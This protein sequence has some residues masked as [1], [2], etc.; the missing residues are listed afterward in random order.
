MGC[1]HSTSWRSALKR[2]FDERVSS[3]ARAYFAYGP[4]IDGT[5]P[6][7]PGS[8]VARNAGEAERAVDEIAARPDGQTVRAHFRAASVE[9]K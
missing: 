5:P 2:Y 1:V 4:I 3:P 6:V 7:W 9:S 8:K